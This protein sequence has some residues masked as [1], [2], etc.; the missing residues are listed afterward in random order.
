MVKSSLAAAISKRSHAGW[1]PHWW[2]LAA[3]HHGEFVDGAHGP[4]QRGHDM[5]PLLRLLDSIE[6]DEDAEAGEDGDDLLELTTPQSSPLSR[7]FARQESSHGPWSWNTRCSAELQQIVDS[8][9]IEKLYGQSFSFTVA[10][11]AQPDCPLV[12][13]SIGF[14]ALTEYS[15]GEIVGRS[16]R[17]LLD[18]VPPKLIDTEMRMRCRQF[19]KS[20]VRS[21]EDG[22]SR[23]H[24]PVELAKP[25][26]KLPAGE[27]ICM[28]V[29]ARKSGELFRNLFYMKQVELDDKLFIVG[30][31][32]GL[33]DT[34]NM[35]VA[36]VDLER[37]CQLA[38]GRLGENM[39]VIEQVLAQ[40]FWYSAPIRRQV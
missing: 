11:P 30:L 37:K 34:L 1:P 3:A 35:D 20:L 24:L 14:T 6:D 7:P 5:D 12:A 32:L 31:Q 19:C 39:S 4:G 9:C 8:F 18:G 27:M 10:D 40:Q 33:P 28:Q 16:C 17:F 21:E 26:M 22:D 2:L 13:C 38:F 36:M 15:V 25:W 29:N 23:E